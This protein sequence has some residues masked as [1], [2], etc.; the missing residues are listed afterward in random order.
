[1]EIKRRDVAGITVLVARKGVNRVRIAMGEWFR[2]LKGGI[3]KESSVVA[4]R[5]LLCE[6]CWPM[7][8]RIN[9]SVALVQT[10]HYNTRHDS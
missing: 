4:W 3:W 10:F 7:D 9:V 2:R 6:I 8:L 5:L 1:M